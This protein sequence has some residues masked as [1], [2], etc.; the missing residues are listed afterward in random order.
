MASSQFYGL[1]VAMTA[2]MDVSCCTVLQ[3]LIISSIVSE[4]PLLPTA[5]IKVPVVKDEGDAVTVLTV[6]LTVGVVNVVEVVVLSVM[7]IRR[8][9]YFHKMTLLS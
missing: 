8:A 2:T 3:T 4:K 5:V 9:E 7:Q 1:R 6:L